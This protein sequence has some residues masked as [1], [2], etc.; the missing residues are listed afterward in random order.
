MTLADF[1]SHY[2]GILIGNCGYSKEDA[3]QRLAD[4]V[5]D[6]AAFGRPFIS[7][8]DLPVRLQNGFP[9]APWD[10]MSKWYTPGPEGYTDYPAYVV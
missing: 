4:G 1:R 8:P 10:D 7:N 3:E 2:P 6:I 5:V 9:L